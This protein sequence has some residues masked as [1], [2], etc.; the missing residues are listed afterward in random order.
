MINTTELRVYMTRNGN[1]SMSELAAKIG[2]SPATLG[3][4]FE[5]RDMPTEFAEKIIAILNIQQKDIVPI[6]FDG[7]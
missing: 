4:W 3:R 7:V 5:S 2:K 1:M 6:F